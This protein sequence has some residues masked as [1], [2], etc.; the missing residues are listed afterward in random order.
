M[1]L[2]CD[3]EGV[4]AW[5]PARLK[6]CVSPASASVTVKGGKTTDPAA[7]SSSQVRLKVLE[8]AGSTG[9]SSFRSFTCSTKLALVVP[10]A[11]VALGNTGLS[12]GFG[13]KLLVLKHATVIVTVKGTGT[14]A[15]AH[16]QIHTHTH[17]HTDT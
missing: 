14:S 6:V 7:C 2:P 16:A 10:V 17:T 11:S 12:F 15:R 5:L 1:T 9:G 3:S 8:P 4:Y 13:L